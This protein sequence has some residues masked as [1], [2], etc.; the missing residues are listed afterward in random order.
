M[1]ALQV[2]SGGSAVSE[3]VNVKIAA[4]CRCA[5]VLVWAE[6]DA[7]LGPVLC[8]WGRRRLV[9]LPAV[10]A[11]VASVDKFA[12]VRP[13]EYGPGPEYAPTLLPSLVP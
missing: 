7:A 2:W 6:T 11:A 12:A 3:P 13:V 4:A 10:L 5:G 1:Y 8:G 9:E